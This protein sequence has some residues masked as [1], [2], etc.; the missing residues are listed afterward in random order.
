MAIRC[1]A[2]SA[3]WVPDLMQQAL[4][5]GG[6]G[7]SGSTLLARLLA[8][9]PGVA[10]VGELMYVAERGYY[11]HELC[12]CGEAFPEC[13][14]WTRV[15]EVLT[16]EDLDVWFSRFSRL[17]RRVARRR[18]LPRILLAQ[19]FATRTRV[20]SSLYSEMLG[21]LMTAV[22]EVSGARVVVDSS[23]EP[24]HGFHLS[25]AKALE[26]RLVHL[27][28]DCRAVTFSLRRSRIRREVRG[29]TEYMANVS[30][31]ESAILWSVLNA[32]TEVLG[33]ITGAYE[34][35]RYESLARQPDDVVDRLYAQAVPG[36]EEAGQRTRPSVSPPIQH[37]VSGNP[38]RFEPVL[39]IKPDDGWVAGLPRRDF[40]ISTILAAPLLIRY[41]YSLGRGAK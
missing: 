36:T 6:Q 34:R 24:L 35:L 39:A 1:G 3:K 31:G 7:R 29:R 9:R 14:F 17:Q 28:R 40:V 23:K 16:E 4:F 21:E 18:S 41:G 37:E 25:R 11:G 33:R 32:M 38:M 10:S 20:E 22:G 19:G 13:E 15:L 27:V 2:A 12:A 8:S 5:I 26:M 30:P